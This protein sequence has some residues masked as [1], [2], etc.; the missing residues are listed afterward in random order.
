MD[1]AQDVQ[2]ASGERPRSR[3]ACVVAVRQNQG[4]KN[5]AGARRELA[6]AANWRSPRISEVKF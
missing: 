3:I 2:G 4:A 5:A 6:L 1:V